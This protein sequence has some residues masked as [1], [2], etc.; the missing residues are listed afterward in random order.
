MTE[1]TVAPTQ[2]ARERAI[3]QVKLE[4]ERGLAVWSGDD[5]ITPI[6][7][8]WEASAKTFSHDDV[9][10]LLKEIDL[11]W[12]LLHSLLEEMGDSV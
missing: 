1:T 10:V 2:T 5:E 8:R 7:L 3:N 6:E 9:G 12:N 11:Y 4:R